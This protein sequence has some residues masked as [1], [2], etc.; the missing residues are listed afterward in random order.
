MRL[1]AHAG[2]FFGL[3]EILVGVGRRTCELLELGDP[4]RPGLVAMN[5]QA[6]SLG[7]PDAVGVVLEVL[8]DLSTEVADRG[9]RNVANLV[10]RGGLRQAEHAAACDLFALV[11]HGRG[12]GRSVVEHD[13]NLGGAVEL[14]LLQLCE[15]RLVLDE[16]LGTVCVFQVGENLLGHARR[17][18]NDDFGVVENGGSHGVE[19]VLRE[20]GAKR[21]FRYVE[22][23]EGELAAGP[24]ND[25][26]PHAAQPE[27][28]VRAEYVGIVEVQKDKVGRVGHDELSD[29]QVCLV[30]RGDILVGAAGLLEVLR[31]FGRGISDVEDALERKGG[32]QVTLAEL[33]EIQN[34]RG[35]VLVGRHDSWGRATGPVLMAVDGDDIDAWVDDVVAHGFELVGEAVLARGHAHLEVEG[36]NIL[37]LVL[38]APHV[39]CGIFDVDGHTVVLVLPPLQTHDR[40][41]QL[42]VAQQH[43]GGRKD[44]VGVGEDVDV[45]FVS[46]GLCGVHHDLVGRAGGD[47]VYLYGLWVVGTNIRLTLGVLADHVDLVE[48]GCA[49]VPG[50]AVT[51]LDVV[52]LVGRVGVEGDKEPHAA[53]VDDGRRG[54]Q[55]K[56]VHERL[57]RCRGLWRKSRGCRLALRR[58]RLRRLLLR[59]RRQRRDVD[60]RRSLLLLLPLVVVKSL[61]R[62]HY[63]KPIKTMV[64][65][66]AYLLK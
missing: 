39:L 38:P 64:S 53:R 9:P 48:E 20:G 33:V 30:V 17:V 25:V 26:G 49:G 16:D 4:V 8:V 6:C 44:D 37:Y 65:L 45:A 66:Y 57:L 19:D 59:L 40:I 47:P 14:G 63:R 58:L 52:V 50:E 29:S 42:D 12:R 18:E 13:G 23:D 62:V 61:Y 24:Q 36:I 5:P 60:G 51:H 1:I 3:D 2:Y 34:A 32:S 43:D 22:I 7:D 27:D 41:G 35:R 11:D 15:S 55:E 10:G 31:E 21:V 56:V 28:G 46:V 54:F